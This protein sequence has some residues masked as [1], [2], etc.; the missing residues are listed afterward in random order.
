MKNVN[1][2]F[3]AINHYVST[4]D[5]VGEGFAIDAGSMIIALILY[6]PKNPTDMTDFNRFTARLN[7]I[8]VPHKL[9]ESASQNHHKFKCSELHV[10]KTQILPLAAELLRS[11][12]NAGFSSMAEII[13]A[14][15]SGAKARIIQLAEK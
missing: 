8:T 11:P 2:L 1:H 3:F 15:F 4:G 12:G 6:D 13:D 7:E 5:S 10:A 14:V 9:I